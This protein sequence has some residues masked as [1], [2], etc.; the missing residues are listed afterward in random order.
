MAGRIKI[1]QAFSVLWYGLNARDGL[2]STE[3]CRTLETEL[4]SELDL[5]LEF[6]MLTYIPVQ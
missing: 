1:A 2:A 6:E 4:S 5:K 3:Y